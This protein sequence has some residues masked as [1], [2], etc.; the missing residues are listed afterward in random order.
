MHTYRIVYYPL[1]VAGIEAKQQTIT[2][3]SISHAQRQA[4]RLYPEARGS[5]KQCE[6]DVNG[7]REQV[8]EFVKSEGKQVIESHLFVIPQ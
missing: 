1:L 4:S 6:G 2:A 8:N 7:K 3:N 5:W